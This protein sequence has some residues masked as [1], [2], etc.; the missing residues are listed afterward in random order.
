M[1]LSFTTTSTDVFNVRVAVALV[2]HD[3]LLVQGDVRYPFLLPPGGRCRL[4]E[5]TSEA[6]RRE[7][8][9]ELGCSVEI[10]RLL[11]LVESFFGFDGRRVHELT[12]VYEGILPQDAPFLDVDGDFKGAEDDPRLFFRW[13]PLA[14]LAT[15]ELYPEVL[16]FSMGRFP[17]YTERVVMRS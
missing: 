10:K 9:E 6:A 13:V 1:D 3:R 11:W 14:S 8:A 15:L 16:R 7:V 2:H 5:Q 17:S 4:N 12:F